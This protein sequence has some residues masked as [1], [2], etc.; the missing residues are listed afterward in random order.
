[1]IA[2]LNKYRAAILAS[3]GMLGL[4]LGLMVSNLLFQLR[5]LSTAAGDNTQWSISQLDTEFA[6]LNSALLDKLANGDQ[7]FDDI[8]LRVDIALS[9]LS[10]INSGRAGEV[11]GE[12]DKAKA[13]I[14]P[15]NAFAAQ[16]ITIIDRPGALTKTDLSSLRDLVRDI[17]PNVREIAL[18][19]VSLGAERSQE[20]R[21]LFA[22]QLTR[23]GGIAIALLLMMTGLMVLLDRLLRRT[24]LRDAELLASSKQLAATVAASLDAIVTADAS[25]K[26]IEFNAS[27]EDVFG[28]SRDEIIGRTMEETF[29]PQHMR[30]AHHDGMKRYLA[31]GLPR[32]VDG[33]RVELAALRKAGDEFPVELNITTFKKGEDT[34]FIAYIRDISERKI[35][36]QKL[37]D[38]RDRAERTDKAKSQFLTVMSHEMR[39]PLNGILG[40]LD[41]LKTTKLTQKQKRYAQIATASSEILLEHINEALDITRIEAGALLVTPQNFVLLELVTS[42]TDVLEPLAL[43][44]NL[45]ITLQIEDSMQMAF[46]GD[47]NRIR[48][49]LTNLIGNAIKFTDTGHVGLEVS[50]IHGP[51]H[52]YAKFAVTDTGAGI[53]PRHQEQV[54]EDFVAL[55]HGDGRQTRGD[56]L[57][58][59]ISRKIARRLGGDITL[60]SE[61]GEGS[62]FTLTVPLQRRKDVSQVDQSVSAPTHQ[63]GKVCKILVVEDNSINRKVLGD[64]LRGMGHELHEA[65]DGKDC[66]KK[67][68]DQP[69]DLIFMDISMPV[70]DG[71]EAT[72]RLRAGRGPNASTH[73][74][75]LT[76]HGRE[77]YRE[78]AGRAGM[79][80]FHTKPIRLDALRGIISELHSAA[81]VPR[82]TVL[83]SD[84]LSELIDALGVG[85]AQDIG[86]EYF[87]ELDAFFSQAHDGT[88]SD[89]SDLAT[90]AHKMKGAAA[91][92]G[93]IDL[94]LPFGALEQAARADDLTD[95][96]ARIDQLE[97]IARV[98]CTN[99]NARVN[100]ATL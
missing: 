38:A 66:L 51:L 54:F 10:I 27:A 76:A 90:A 71:L 6:N 77:E 57:G 37:I 63:E 30:D 56:G 87:A 42:L 15:L 62:T 55:S 45:N 39:T 12:N 59:S 28:W 22:Q 17:R 5:D 82:N 88:L 49:I 35:T 26:I 3:L 98:A 46:F 11:F 83:P 1:M 94:E 53:A 43:E 8:Q 20:R 7:S 64:M 52:S 67:A 84:A 13:L 73:I 60:A 86:S 34:K 47:S 19:G 100:A 81:D 14:A 85:K 96:P 21:A 68:Q 29:I 18:L 16:A 79:N 78:G 61:V 31:T 44:K 72:R 50:G 58:L 9:R 80:R 89:P 70:M 95:L 99:F 36:E 25:G 92:L 75:G 40:V 41:L 74:V 32:V 24:M 2:G 91:M 69:F 97:G 65:V 48:Q 23:T 33:G 4:F 93:Q